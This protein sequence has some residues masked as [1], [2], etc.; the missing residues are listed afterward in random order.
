LRQRL[1]LVRK[2][3]FAINDGRT[4]SGIVAIGLAIADPLGGL[5]ALSLSMPSTRFSRDRIRQ[6]V[7]SMQVCRSAIEQVTR[8]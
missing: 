5:A 4:E 6:L 7:G 3:G 8:G 2:S 1:S